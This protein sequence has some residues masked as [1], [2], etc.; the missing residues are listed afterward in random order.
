MEPVYH[1]GDIL[2]VEMTDDVNIGEIGIFYADGK[3]YVKKRGNNEL[4]SLNP[5]YNNI[6]VNETSKCMGKVVGK[7][8]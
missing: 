2:L 8:N 7:L 4:I 6:S 3:S 5:K 1:D